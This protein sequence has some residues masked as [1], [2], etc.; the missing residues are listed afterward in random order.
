MIRVVKS[1]NGFDDMRG[2]AVKFKASVRYEIVSS[3]SSSKLPWKNNTAKMQ[4]VYLG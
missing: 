2:A 1:T 4:F 3:N